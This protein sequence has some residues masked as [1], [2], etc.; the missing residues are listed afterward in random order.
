MMQDSQESERRL[1]IAEAHPEGRQQE[2][3][4]AEER[5]L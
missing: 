5:D 3:I 2:G 1:E 4:P